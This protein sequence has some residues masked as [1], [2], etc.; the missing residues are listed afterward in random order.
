MSK[1][2]KK[3][4]LRARAQAPEAAVPATA[5][6]PVPAPRPVDEALYARV[7]AAVQ[8]A[9]QQ[10]GPGT[11]LYNGETVSIKLVE[12]GADAP[13]RLLVA[14]FQL[15]VVYQVEGDREVVRRPGSWEEALPG[16]PAT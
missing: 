6:A 10:D 2:T 9:G 3:Q 1:S 12:G 5:P 8:A 11:W 13:R 15:G 7:L 16:G 14:A 4:R